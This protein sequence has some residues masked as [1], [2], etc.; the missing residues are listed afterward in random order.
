MAKTV[1]VVGAGLMGSGI[2]QS[3]AMAGKN[4]RLYDISEAA[5]EKGIAS[6]QKSLARFVKTGKLSEQDAQQTLQRIH[7]GTD[8]QEMVQE[9]DVVIEAVPEDLSLKKNVF[10]KLDRYTK[11]EA[12]LATNTS[13]LSVTAIA[14]ATT[15]PDKV[16]GMHW[17]NP[18]PVMKLIEIVKGVTTSEET[19]AAIQ[20]LSEEIGKE[21]VVVED[22]QGFVTTRAIAAHMIECIRM[23][24]EGVA[25]AE[26]IDKAVRLGLN[27]PMGPLELADM[28]GLDTMLFVSENL[29]EAYGDR[30]RAPQIL[31]KLVEAGHL[32]RKTGKGFY[33]YNE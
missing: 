13:E 3:V 27:Y 14:S 19:I 20:Q 30:F 17:F 4:V 21:T 18:A 22:R 16:I 15:R 1:A 12:I 9:A 11:R 2:A 29:T 24:E 10:Q 5:L 32:G 23:Y 28:V 31:R 7:T 8:L 6:I 33:T 26:D 25:T